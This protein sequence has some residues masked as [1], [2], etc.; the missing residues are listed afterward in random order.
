MST[1]NKTL[2]LILNRLKPF[3]LANN[4]AG[5][6]SVFDE[7]SI[8]VILSK[9][10]INFCRNRNESCLVIFICSLYLQNIKNDLKISKILN[11][12]QKIQS[13]KITSSTNSFKNDEYLSLVCNAIIDQTLYDSYSDINA[14]SLEV[15]ISIEIALDFDK[16]KIALIIL[17]NNINKIIKNNELLQL[18]FYLCNRN[19]CITPDRHANWLDIINLYEYVLIKIKSKK[20]IQLNSKLAL[21]L[22][23]I[24]L[25]SKKYKELF[26]YVPLV[27]G[28]ED[29]ASMKFQ[30]AIATCHLNRLPE[31]INYLDELISSLF[32]ESDDFI[33][34]KFSTDG[35]TLQSEKKDLSIQ[36]ISI[37]LRHLLLIL[38][39]ENRQIF[40]V[41]GTLLGYAREKSILSHD[42]DVDLGMIYH[43]DIQIT[44]AAIKKSNSFILKMYHSGDGHIY[45]IGLI[46]KLTNTPIDIFIYHSENGKLLTG[47]EH[48]FGY[49]QK[50]S[51]TPFELKLIHFLNIPIYIPENFELNL[52]ENFGNWRLPDEN[53]ISHLE[54]PSTIDKGGLVYMIVL[55]LELLKSIKELNKYKLQKIININNIHKYSKYCIPNKLLEKIH[56]RWL[57]TLIEV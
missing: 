5:I 21:A 35:S 47:V 25:T 13:G 2:K 11:C 6:E 44:I 36:G 4:M 32:K 48:S 30:L 39:Q 10:F 27:S 45:S 41:S 49:L 20:L 14:T 31:S 22:N 46:H 19:S 7:F 24:F 42:K 37:A 23:Q 17:K 26:K 52:Q 38:A 12:Y 28:D 43:D 18:S 34:N 8:E 53:Y 1:R 55:R 15:L 51:F 33:R 50:F 54:S 9:D 16:P 40:L 29:I 57:P 3:V 56:A